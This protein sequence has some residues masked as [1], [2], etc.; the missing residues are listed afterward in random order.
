MI[1]SF[2]IYLVRLFLKKLLTISLI[3][4]SLVFILSIFDEISFFRNLDINFFF[5]FLITALNVP[6]TLF[7]I[8]PFI[9]LISTQ[10]FFL[11]LINKNELEVMKIHGLNN[12]KIIKILKHEYLLDAWDCFKI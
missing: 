8:F 6:S 4:L 3:F 2:E 10:F 7:E 11:E 1:K 9:F 12:F 5:P